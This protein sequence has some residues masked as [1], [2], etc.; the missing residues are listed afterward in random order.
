M[1][2]PVFDEL[3][4]P[5][6][7]AALHRRH[8]RRRH[9]PQP[10]DRP[11]VPAPAARRARSRPCSSGSAATARSAPTRRRSRSSARTPACTRRA[12]SSTTRRSRARSRSPTCG[13][14]REPIRLDLPGRAR[15]TSSPATSSA[16]SARRRSSR[17]PRHGAT[18]LLN[19]P[20]RPGRG[21]GADP[22][23]GP[24][25]ARRQA[26]RPVGDRRR[27]GRQGRRHGQPD[28]H[29]HA[30][31][32]LRSSPS[33]LPADE[34]IARIKDFDRDDLRQARRR[35][36]SQRNFAADR[37]D[38]WPRC[39]PRAAPRGAARRACR[40][41]SRSRPAPRTSSRRSPRS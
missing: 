1:V 5:R 40:P 12:T 3:A 17:R 19:A 34:A 16:C 7:E 30:A 2:K 28:Q 6:A 26:D 25:A 14:A 18:L 31:V 21:L 33:V 4:A 11:V 38:R 35:A 24:A 10:A 36:S 8:R 15:P 22:R 39:T 13:S 23:R 20:V 9:P 41:R 32:L 29:R 27:G 37:H